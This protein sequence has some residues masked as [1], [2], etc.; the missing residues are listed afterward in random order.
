[1]IKVAEFEFADMKCENYWI[2]FYNFGDLIGSNVSIYNDCREVNLGLDENK[3]YQISLDQSTSCTGIFIKDYK[4]TEAYMIEFSRP[5]EWQADDYIFALENLLHGICSGKLISHII[6]ERPISNKNYR[7]SQ[8][9]FQLEG[10]I[11]S[12]VKRY[13]EFRSAR[14][15]FIEN[16]SWRSVVIKKEY[17]DMNDRKEASRHSIVSI[18][19]WSSIYGYSIGKDNDI[20][21][22]MGV[23][24]GWF[25]NSFD[26]LG[27]PYVRGD[28]FY[29]TI[30]GFLLP[31]VSSKDVSE[32]F[33]EAGIQSIWLVQNPKKS[34]YEN[35]A[36]AVE[37]HKVVC[38]EITEPYAML[39]LVV[40]C[41]IKW[42]EPDKMTVVLVAT[43]YVD[44]RVFEITG[45]TYHFII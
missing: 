43:N 26:T 2:N 15:E 30:G 22:A 39:A 4:N 16:Q 36:S 40:E 42:T 25:I 35:L 18:Y 34:I 6:Y 33:N 3:T 44:K 13:D 38:V 11:R 45:N 5:N 7:S 29:G 21:E 23:M 17:K 14:L 10:M 1:M 20:F 37:K 27:R 8:V 24:F 41:N 32:K 9:L 19:D 31:Y 28:R 12:L